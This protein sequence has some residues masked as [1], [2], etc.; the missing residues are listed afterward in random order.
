MGISGGRASQIKEQV[1]ACHI[2]TTAKKG[3]WSKKGGKE[4]DYE[5][6]GCDYLSEGSEQDDETT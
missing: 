4:Q 2:P 5:I 6:L 1:K 3:A